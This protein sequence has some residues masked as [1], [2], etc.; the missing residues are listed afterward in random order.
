VDWVSCQIVTLKRLHVALTWN[1]DA[2]IG[3]KVRLQNFGELLI[4]RTAYIDPT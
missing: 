4:V 3:L 1:S 2:V